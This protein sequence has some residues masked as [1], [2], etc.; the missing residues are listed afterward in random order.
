MFQLPTTS[1]N[2][3]THIGTLYNL[4]PQED[5]PSE[6]DIHYWTHGDDNEDNATVHRMID[7]L[8][9]AKEL[10]N[11]EDMKRRLHLYGGGVELLDD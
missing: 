3:P 9:D 11:T 5:L 1:K 10:E 4:A 2:P 8:E 6:T 7:L